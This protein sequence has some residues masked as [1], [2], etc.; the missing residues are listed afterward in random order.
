MPKHHIAS[1]LCVLHVLFSLPNISFPSSLS[2]VLLLVCQSWFE[3]HFF[4]ETF[5]NTCP[6]APTTLTPPSFVLPLYAAWTT[7]II[8]PCS[9]VMSYLPA[10]LP[11]LVF[12]LLK[13]F[14]A[15]A[16]PRQRNI[17]VRN[18]GTR[19]S[20]WESPWRNQLASQCL[21]FLISQKEDTRSTSLEGLL[22]WGLNKMMHVKCLEYDPV[23]RNTQ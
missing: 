9:M 14:R 23:Y 7:T 13:E 16:G 19:L 21:S 10:C 22:L 6:S 5:P 18:S 1:L 12:E 17:I 2:P 15:R 11:L 3:Y 4:S 8:F 20:G